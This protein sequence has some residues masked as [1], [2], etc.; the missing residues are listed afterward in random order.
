MTLEIKSE[1]RLFGGVQ[2]VY[3]FQSAACDC[4][5]EFAAYLPPQAE[6]EPCPALFWLSGL[7]CT[8]ENFTVKAGAQRLASELGLVIIAPDTSPRGED[9]AD[10]EAWDFGKGAGF[11]LDATQAPWAAHYRMESHITEELPAVISGKLP[12]DM[13]RIGVSGHSMGGHGALTLAMRHPELF[14]SLSAFAP[15]VAPSQVPW[16]QKAFQGY[17]GDDPAAWAE[18]DACA[19]ARSRGWTGDILIDQG[20]A[21]T[22]LER[23]LKPHLFAQACAEAGI[24]LT[25]RLQPGYD[26]SYNCMATFIDDHLNWHAERLGL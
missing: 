13:S 11:Y 2:R 16:G 14:V 4:P 8:W 7:T 25:L 22:F 6:E 1:S 12:V 21:D 20:T 18:H 17:L 3:R 15:I 5:M 9:V 26:H 19:L 10:V 24:G 23:E